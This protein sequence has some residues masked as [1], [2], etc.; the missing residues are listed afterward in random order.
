MY[1]AMNVAGHGKRRGCHSC[2]PCAMVLNK[3]AGFHLTLAVRR[4]S[5]DVRTRVGE[6]LWLGE[7]SQTPSTALQALVQG[8]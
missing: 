5:G 3:I 1:D 7:G 6:Y 2:T 4:L 8:H